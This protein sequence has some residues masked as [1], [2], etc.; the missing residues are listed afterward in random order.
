MDTITQKQK[1]KK[2][3]KLLKAIKECDK[4]ILKH[5]QFLRFVRTSKDDWNLKR[6]A[7]NQEIRERIENYYN[8][9]FKI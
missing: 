9:S 7:I 2:A 3:I 4:R 1:H 5:N 8:K 6:I